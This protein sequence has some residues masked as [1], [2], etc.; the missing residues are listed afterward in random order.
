[1]G[2]PRGATLPRRAI[3]AP[4]SWSTSPGCQRARGQSPLWYPGVQEGHHRGPRCRTASAERARRPARPPDRASAPARCSGECPP[5]FRVPRLSPHPP[6]YVSRH[7]PGPRDRPLPGDQTD[8]SCS[9]RVRNPAS[10]QTS[11]GASQA[12]A[13]YEPDPRRASGKIGSNSSIGLPDGSLTRICLP[14]M[15]VTISLRK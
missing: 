8:V 10:T 12:V 13:P 1:M 5:F 9:K 2:G 3:L 11:R 4:R 15:P 6:L 14:P 7:M